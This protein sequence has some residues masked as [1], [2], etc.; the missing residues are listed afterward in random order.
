MSV[1]QKDEALYFAWRALKGADF[2]RQAMQEGTLSKIADADESCACALA[3]IVDSALP[4]VDRALDGD[5][6][7]AL[8]A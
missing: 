2:I 8:P 4:Y 1:E 5:V 6:R 7:P 3:C